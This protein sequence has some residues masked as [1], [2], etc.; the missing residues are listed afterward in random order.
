MINL[1]KSIFISI[2]PFL[3]LTGTVYST[4]QLYQNGFSWEYVG[5]LTAAL[6]IFF[7]FAN[8]FVN[9]KPRT[10]ANLKG[11]TFLIFIGFLVS[12]VAFFKGNYEHGYWP[13][14]LLVAWILYIKWY[15][16]FDNRSTNN[17]ILR[18]G[19]LLPDFEL[20]DFKKEKVRAKN[21]QGKPAIFMFYRG[22]WCPLCMAQIEEIAG[23]YRELERRGVQ[24]VL[25]SPQPH[26]YTT[27]VS[28]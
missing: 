9:K 4:F 16:V 8:I 19:N 6:P 23:K 11:F 1:L 18:V 20:E 25:I 24:M 26:K 28:F 12:L 15:S 17:T 7:F 2:L 5:L 27:S 21:F 22:N 14:V 10:D 3:G 13:S